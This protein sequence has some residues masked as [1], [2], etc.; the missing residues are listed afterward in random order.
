MGIL[1]N[2]KDLIIDIIMYIS[3]Y[4]KLCLRKCGKLLLK[5][6]KKEKSL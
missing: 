4:D 5:K 1:M 2:I 3:L 6:G